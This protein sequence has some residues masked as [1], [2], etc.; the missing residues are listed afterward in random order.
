[1]SGLQ[2][3]RYQNKAVCV[4][5]ILRSLA[6]AGALAV[7]ACGGT[8]AEPPLAG[9][10]IGGPVQ[11]VDGNGRPFTGQS[12]TGKWQI[13]YFGYTFCPD[14]C[15]TDVA[16]IGAGL[17]KFEGEAPALGRQVV[18][19][20]VTVDPERDTPAV[21]KQFAAS[22]HP[23]MIGLTGTPQQI[24][25]AAKA[26]AVYYQRGETA[27]GGGYL[28]DHGR[29]TYLMDPAGK[30]VVLVPADQ[31]ADAVAATLRQWVR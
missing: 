31:G 20:F 29:Q 5:N 16:A 6:L 10:R 28:M 26:Y 22:F 18:P 21:V 7:A 2:P 25:A 14:V 19:V 3:C 30:P 15:P 17:K 13:V 24:A 1:M 4:M 23:R 12:L 11:L 9:A 27:P 8:P